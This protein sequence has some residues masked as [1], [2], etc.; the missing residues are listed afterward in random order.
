MVEMLVSHCLVATYNPR[1]PAVRLDAAYYLLLLL[2]RIIS[3]M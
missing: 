3:V 1:T 2:L